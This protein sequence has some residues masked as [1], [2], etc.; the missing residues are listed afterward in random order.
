MVW[1]P[2]FSRPKAKGPQNRRTL[3][4]IKLAQQLGYELTVP[5]PVIV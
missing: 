1:N 3:T 2:R 4:H 5:T